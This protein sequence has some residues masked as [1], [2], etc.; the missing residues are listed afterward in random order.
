MRTFFLFHQSLS[1][2]EDDKKFKQNVREFIEKT[3][4]RKSKKMEEEC[5]K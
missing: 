4:E 1:F 2:Q 3:E 5:F